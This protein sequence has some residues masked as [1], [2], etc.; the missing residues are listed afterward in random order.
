ML[1]GASLAKPGPCL[2][3]VPIAAEENVYPMVPPGAANRDMIEGGT[4]ALAR[5]L[6]PATEL[7]RPLL[8]PAPSCGCWCAITLA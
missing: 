3:N 8:A 1:A 2:V 7:P 6:N 4:N 5:R